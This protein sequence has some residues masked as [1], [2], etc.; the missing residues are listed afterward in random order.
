[1]TAFTR[2]QLSEWGRRGGQARQRLPDAREH[3]RRAGRASAAK[4][5]MRALGRLGFEATVARHGW[6]VA[7]EAARRW[8]IEHPSQPERQV[9]EILDAAYIAYE[10]EARAL[11]DLVPVAVD[12]LCDGGK[13]IEVNGKVHTDPFFSDGGDRHSREA[14][15]LKRLR[16]IYDVL[17][18]DWRD[19]A[20][21]QRVARR[22]V[23]FLEA[24]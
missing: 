5:D 21:R 1:M 2:E 4:N 20:D 7:F 19:L 22:I 6:D 9:A 10:R 8:R 17:V 23:E 11:G 16:S 15:R 14:A 18:I 12:F 24:S 3:Q 13:I